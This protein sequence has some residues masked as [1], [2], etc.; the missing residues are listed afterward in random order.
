MLRRRPPLLA[1]PE[2]NDRPLHRALDA[3]TR[4]GADAAPVFRRIGRHMTPHP[5]ELLPDPVE[6]F[7][8]WRDQNRV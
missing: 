8:Y 5:W 1:P 2:P 7:V 6:N 3:R 4:R